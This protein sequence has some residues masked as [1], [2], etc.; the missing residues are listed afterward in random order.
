MAR[1]FASTTALGATLFVVLGAATIAEGRPDA[2]FV[3]RS[4]PWTPWVASDIEGSPCGFVGWSDSIAEWSVC[5][6]G[7][8]CTW[9]GYS[10]RSNLTLH[11]ECNGGFTQGD[12]CDYIAGIVPTRCPQTGSMWD[13]MF[14][15]FIPN[16]ESGGADGDYT[17]LPPP[18]GRP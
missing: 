11:G 8:Y 6:D 10:P 16:D 13:D 18:S 9:H 7:S 4:P 5:G 2:P 3:D 12:I 17:P 14:D 15:E 1:R